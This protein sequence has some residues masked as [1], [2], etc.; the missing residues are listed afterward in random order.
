MLR[1]PDIVIAN[2]LG[3]DREIDMLAVKLLIWNRGSGIPERK[4]QP[5]FHP[6]YSLPIRPIIAPAAPP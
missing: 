2:V 6:I 1:H 4:Q 3:L 5:E